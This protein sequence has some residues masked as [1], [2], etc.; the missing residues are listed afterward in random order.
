M[1]A[2][3]LPQGLAGCKSSAAARFKSTR[4]LA[5]LAPFPSMSAT[6]RKYQYSAD[7]NPL[8]EDF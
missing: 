7:V 5:T 1:T 6:P 2:S 3:P 8:S 4:Y